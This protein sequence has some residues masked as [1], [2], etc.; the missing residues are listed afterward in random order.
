MIATRDNL[1]Q[2]KIIIIDNLYETIQELVND[3]LVMK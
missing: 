3:S 1:S 2:R